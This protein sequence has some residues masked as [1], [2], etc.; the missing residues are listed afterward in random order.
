MQMAQ[1][2]RGTPP[3]LSGMAFTAVLKLRMPSCIDYGREYG[4]WDQLPNET[5]WRLKGSPMPS[6]VRALPQKALVKMTLSE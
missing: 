4:T 3:L 1:G 6:Q 5:L 2:R